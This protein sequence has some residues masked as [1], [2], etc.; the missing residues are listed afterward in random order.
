M[1]CLCGHFESCPNCNPYMKPAKTHV[2]KPYLSNK[3]VTKRVLK[4][5]LNTVFTTKEQV[6]RTLKILGRMGVLNTVEGRRK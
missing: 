6:E 5:K 3:E 1:N 2:A 4:S